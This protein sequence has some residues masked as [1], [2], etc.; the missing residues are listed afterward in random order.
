M[1]KWKWKWMGGGDC[2]VRLRRWGTHSRMPF[3]L[4]LSLSSAFVG[5]TGTVI[6]CDRDARRLETL[7]GAAA[8]SR[9]SAIIRPLHADFLSL[10]PASRP[11]LPLGGVR[12]ILLDPSCS[13]SGT[14]AVRGDWLNA[15]AAVGG[16]GKNDEQEEAERGAARLERLASFQ[17]AALAHALAAFPA[18]VRVTYSTCSVH[19]REN[20]AVVARVLGAGGA[21]AG[22]WRLEAA[23]PAW[24]RRGVAGTVDGLSDAEAACLVRVDPILDETDGFFVALF[25]RE[26]AAVDAGK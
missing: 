25:V 23:L 2:G 20:E 14:S 6:G 8:R 12:A 5:P 10:S 22:G 21:R 26:E 13:G 16:G 11:D 19:V 15:A 7:A 3:P 9:T 18:A 17:E 1:G 4:S 24:P